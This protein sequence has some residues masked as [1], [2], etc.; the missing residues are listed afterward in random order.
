MQTQLFEKNDSEFSLQWK[1]MYWQ[2]ALRAMAKRGAGSS[3]IFSE[4]STR[5]NPRLELILEL[6]TSLVVNSKLQKSSRI[7]HPFATKQ[8]VVRLTSHVYYSQ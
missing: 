1:D 4:N 3:Q 7:S 8:L 2:N 5:D 6:T